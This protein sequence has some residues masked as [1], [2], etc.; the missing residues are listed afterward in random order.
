MGFCT[1]LFIETLAFSTGR[2][3]PTWQSAGVTTGRSAPEKVKISRQR[4]KTKC[5]SRPFPHCRNPPK[6]LIFHFRVG[7]RALFGQKNDQ[8]LTRKGSVSVENWGLGVRG[9]SDWKSVV[10][11]RYFLATFW[12]FRG[13]F[14]GFGGTFLT[15]SGFSGKL[16]FF[17]FFSLF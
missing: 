14:W 1:E 16:H 13:T 6:P 15:F 11:I 9:C 7:K 8:K 2:S 12:G 17:A 3:A 5:I 4:P 10:K